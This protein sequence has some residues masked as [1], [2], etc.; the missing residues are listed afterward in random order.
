[1]LYYWGIAITYTIN[2]QKNIYEKNYTRNIVSHLFEVDNIANIK[3]KWLKYWVYEIGT[4]K[5]VIKVLWCY[6]L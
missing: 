3:L 1:M 6:L 5:L 4:K 2:C